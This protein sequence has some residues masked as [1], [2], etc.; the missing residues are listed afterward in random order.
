MAKPTHLVGEALDQVSPQGV[1]IAAVG[2]HVELSPE[3][4]HHDW[5]GKW[6]QKSSSIALA[7]SSRISSRTWA[8]LLRVIA[9]SDCFSLQEE[10]LTT[11]LTTYPWG[12]RGSRRGQPS[13]AIV[14]IGFL[15][16]FMGIP[17]GLRAPT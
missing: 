5:S 15:R 1:Q 13:Y 12:S 8:Y 4:E 6:G 17:G 11:Y 9:G 3:A 10:R 2:I 7:A 14:E 16:G